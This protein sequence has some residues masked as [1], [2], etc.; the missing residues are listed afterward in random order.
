M[1]AGGARAVR[2]CR[3]CLARSC[4]YARIEIEVEKIGDQVEHGD[5]HR[6]RE[7]PA[8]EHGVVAVEHGLVERAPDAGPGED[9]L[10]QDGAGD[11]GPKGERRHGDDGQKR[12]A[13]RMVEDDP[14][15]RNAFRPGG[16]D[17]VLAQGLEHGGAHDQGVF[18]IKRE[19]E[20]RHRHDHVTRLVH[21]GLAEGRI[22]QEGIVHARG[23]Q[24]AGEGDQ[25]HQTEE[26]GGEGVE[27]DGGPGPEV[28]GEGVAP[29]GG[30]NSNGYA[31]YKGYDRADR[32][33]RQR[34]AE[35]L[36]Q[37]VQDRLAV[38]VGNAQISVR[39]LAQVEQELL[40]DRLV[41]AELNL[42]RML[43]FGRGV[44]NAGN[45]GDRAARQNPE[46]QEI[47]RERGDDGHDRRSDALEEI[48]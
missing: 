23:G 40:P 27:P 6:D 36:D 10:D 18:G 8:L 34:I 15:A 35:R 26:L 12:I 38:D 45:P 39:E 14:L 28:V 17:V 7:E 20:G 2:S 47:Q 43:E 16:E 19:H 5:H 9:H 31:N 44:G 48:L 33:H 22:D 4:G 41:E 1:T 37:I 30:E 13:Q 3:T 11:D 32:D 46:Q 25:D 29:D 21:E 42:K 24:H